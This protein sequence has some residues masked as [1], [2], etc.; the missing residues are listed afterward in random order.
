MIFSIEDKMGEALISFRVQ[1]RRTPNFYNRTIKSLA[2]PELR[3]L[4]Y[5][6]AEALLRILNMRIPEELE[7]RLA[8]TRGWFHSVVIE[9]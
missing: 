4:R 8:N 1:F 7:D 3:R 2:E 5:N 9:W 6:L